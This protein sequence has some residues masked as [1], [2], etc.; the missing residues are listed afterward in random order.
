MP[1]SVVPGGYVV[2]QESALVNHLNGGP[3]IPTF[4]PPMPFEQGVRRRPTLVNNAE[5]LAQLALIARHGATWFRELGTPSQPGSALVTLSGP[6]AYAGVYEIEH[7]ASLT[8]ADRCRRRR[9]RGAARGAARRLRRHMDRRL[10]ARAA[11]RSSDEHLARTTHRS[12]PASCC[13]SRRTPARWPRP[14]AS[15]AGWPIRARA[16]ADRA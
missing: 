15:L 8:L 3:A 9:H 5:T 16:S 4:T 13:C 10:A 6:V 2:G 1:L 11:S 7:G 12:A 14:R